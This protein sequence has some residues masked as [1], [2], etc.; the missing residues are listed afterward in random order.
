MQLATTGK[1]DLF[2]YLA[3]GSKPVA[4]DYLEAEYNYVSQLNNGGVVITF[5]VH[6]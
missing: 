1:G 3:A 6:M 4:N 2:R 5:H